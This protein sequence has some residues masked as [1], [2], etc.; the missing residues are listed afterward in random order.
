M[1][2]FRLIAIASLLAMIGCGGGSRVLSTNATSAPSIRAYNGTASVGDFLSLSIDSVA[3]TITYHNLTNGDNGTVSY[4]VNA[5]GTYAIND[6]SG[7]LLS[8]YEVPSYVL[9]IEANKT[10]PNRDTPSLITAVTQASI[11][12]DTWKSQSFNYMQFR[13]SSGGVD[14]GTVSL[15]AQG[16]A[17]T[18]S[19]WPYG[20][21]NMGSDEFGGYLMPSTSF[22]NGPTGTYLTLTDPGGSTDY[23]FGTANG[24]FAV[25]T[26][27]GAILGFKK[28][29]T[30]DFDPSVA[31]TYNA[32]YY[33]KK[34]ATV[35][36]GNVENGTPALNHTVVTVSG[37]GQITAVDPHGNTLLTATLTPVADALYLY[38]GS[39]SKLADPC[40]GLFTFRTIQGGGTQDT[41]VTFLNGAML[42][43]QFA[44]N[45][46]TGVGYDYLYGVG[47]K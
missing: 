4:T 8:A 28:A 17:T 10:G 30:K 2:S 24:V 25:D 19:Y 35:G 20:A 6:P 1:R 11:S 18:S 26:A 27:N 36:A 9:L 12:V 22:Q 13:T 45:S 21:L 37:S 29:A 42:F 34:G 23:V 14:V 46:S 31:G 5:D 43:S 39:P 47:L 32:V 38:D 3:Q 16:N 41:F 44:S 7:N 15:D 40:F 33:Q